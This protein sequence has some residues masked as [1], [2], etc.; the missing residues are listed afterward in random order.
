MAIF[1]TP[2]AGALSFVPLVT[3]SA[4]LFLRRD[5]RSE[6]LRLCPTSGLTMAVVVVRLPADVAGS[7]GPFLLEGSSQVDLMNFTEGR[8]RPGPWSVLPGFLDWSPSLSDTIPF[9]GRSGLRP[10]L[11]VPWW[12]PIIGRIPVPA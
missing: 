10:V 4:F 6:T 8:Q 5:L 7:V 1:A 11:P 9:V 12:E 3:V 2:P